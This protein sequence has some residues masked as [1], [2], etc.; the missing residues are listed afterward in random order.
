MTRRTD[1]YPDPADPRIGVSLFSTWRVGTP[2]RQKEAVEAIGRAWERRAWPAS[3]L[4]GYHVYAGE[5]GETLLHYSQWA[6]EQAFEAFV[7]THRQ[8]RVDEIDTAVP[9]IERVGLHRYRHHRSGARQDGA[10]PGCVVI[11]DVEFEGPD[12]GR[13]RDWA[14]AVLDALE[15]EPDPHPGGISAHFHLGV[16]GTRVL[17][18]AEWESARAHADALAG[19]GNGVG[20]ATARWQRVQEWPGLRSS[21]VRRYEH[22]LGLVPG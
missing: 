8:E 4:L 2:E 17:N 11:V 5:D 7:K 20:S 16:D 9:G 12:H 15:S 19:P 18:Y 3:G 6:S 13:T 1:R 14:D 10:V 22:A 21:T